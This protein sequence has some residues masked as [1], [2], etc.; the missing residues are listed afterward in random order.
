MVDKSTS[1]SVTADDVAELAGVSRWTVNR[2]FK[3]NAS[4]SASARTRVMAA[5]KELG[6]APDLLASSLA[7][8]RSNLVALLV[9]DFANPHK[10]VML[11]T[12]TN[13]LRQNG[14]D[15]LLVNTL[16]SED[17]SSALLT[18][19]QRRVDAAVLIG[20]QFDD[21]IL[22][23]ALVAKRIRKLILFARYS[24]NANTISIC[25]DDQK[26]METI[27]AYVLKQG[28]QKPLFVAGPQHTS[29]H[30]LRWETFQAQWRHS[31]GNNPEHLVVG[32][33]DPQQAY[34]RVAHHLKSLPRVDF[35]DVL[36]CENDALA[37]GASDAVRYE[38]GLRIPDDVAITGF[39]D[40]PYAA[41]PNYDLTTYAQP[42]KALANGLIE[43]LSG[44]PNL[45]RYSAFQGK[46]VARTSA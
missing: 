19:S 34:D 20:V 18:A 15:T 17:A 14:W 16:N 42:I 28:Y 39:D 11:E 22:Q 31:K 9:D 41:N 30:V 44:E 32:S 43:V 29:A 25:C 12:L 27:G 4:I 37:M 5:A 38:F 23:T 36:V 8:D 35:P 10:L 7:S 1:H 13:V 6:Y 26:A 33:Y 21:K 3:T 2:A 46:I 45:A 40:T 24:D